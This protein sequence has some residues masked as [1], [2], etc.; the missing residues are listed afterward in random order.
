MGAEAPRAGLSAG[1]RTLGV[2][3][4]VLSADVLAAHADPNASLTAADLERR[5]GWAP[6]AS[7]RAAVAGLR[8]AGALAVAPGRG[9]STELTAAG[10]DLLAVAAALEAWLARSP[11][12][13]LE[14]SGAPAR[15][16]IRVLAAGWESTVL[17]ALAERP[18]TLAELGRS[19]SSHSYPALKRRFAQLRGA[20]LIACEDAGA[21]SPAYQPT[22]WLRRAAAPLAAAARWQLRHAP[23]P[24]PGAALELETALLLALPLVE[25]PPGARGACVLAAPAKR[26]AGGEGE[27]RAVTVGVRV[28][29]GRIAALDPA[30]PARPASWALAPPAAWLD[31]IVDGGSDGV[32]LRGP[33]SE[34]AGLLVG[35]LHAALAGP[36]EGRG[37]GG[38]G[39]HQR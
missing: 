12:G 17:R 33:D 9:V 23:D 31:A 1:P 16:S 7:L 26:G 36:V 21:R 6:Q 35:A 10:L 32:R 14:L 20:G 3:A 39:A 37:A 28:E 22:P 38:V 13:P 4:R 19:I 24:P 8:D 27:A 30:P 15:G 11:L 29:D 34:L 5:L 2:F 25:L 18:R